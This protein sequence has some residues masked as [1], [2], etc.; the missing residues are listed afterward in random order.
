MNTIETTII[1]YH[2]DLWGEVVS[3]WERS[4]RATHHFLKTGE[5]DIYKKLVLQIDFMSFNVFCLV[6]EGEV[7]GIL[8]TEG[9]S[10]EMLFMAPEYI[11][12]G[13]GAKLM[14]FAVEELKSTRVEVNEE[15][16][17]A[18]NFYSKFGFVVSGRTEKDPQGRDHPMVQMTL[19]KG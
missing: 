19:V 4:A 6:R 15:N 9:D 11:G 2:K 5:I 3:V 16:T 13:L 18:I 7:I 8:G 14:T 12:C 1:P 10:L 17:H